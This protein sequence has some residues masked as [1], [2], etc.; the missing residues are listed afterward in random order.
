MS[1]AAKF[2]KQFIKAV[3]PPPILRE[4]ERG[5]LRKLAR[6]AGLEL[7]FRQDFTEVTRRSKVLRVLAQH[8]IYLPHIIDSFDYYFDSVFPV[9]VSGRL[10]V[11]LSGPRYHRLVGFSDIPLMFP[12]HT[13]P[14]VTT[15]QYLEFANLSEG[16]IVLDIGAYAAVTSIIFARLVGKSGSV[17]A[18]EADKNNI[19]CAAENLSLAR[20]WF[21]L[22]NITLVEAA[23]WSHCKGLDF[24]SEGTMGSSAV[25]IVGPGRGPLVRVPSTTIEDF[26]VSRGLNRLDFVKIDIEGGEIEVLQASQEIL[27]RLKP[28]LIIE[29]HY[30]EGDMSTDRCRKI[31][32][33][34]GYTTELVPQSGSSTPLIAAVPAELGH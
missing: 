34:Y 16:K 3:L 13:E 10:L 2:V 31:L 15:D 33:G 18:F 27:S 9:Q 21:D 23:V 14:Y 19:V 17:F 30:V 5:R 8:A 12:S 11:D 1:S 28:R 7:S 32:A 24:S 6:E 22:Q 4:R 25:S 29:P 20:K 26:C